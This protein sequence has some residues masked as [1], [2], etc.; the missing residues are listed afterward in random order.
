M[1]IIAVSL[2]K[3]KEKEKDLWNIRS[4][5]REQTESYESYIACKWKSDNEK[6]ETDVVM[7]TFSSKI[8][9]KSKF[10]SVH[11]EPEEVLS[12]FIKDHMLKANA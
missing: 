3:K 5:S 10:S 1:L 7:L 8:A 4:N 12:M 11:K 2:K 6:Q 9:N